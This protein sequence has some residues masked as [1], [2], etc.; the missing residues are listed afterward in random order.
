MLQKWTKNSSWLLILLLILPTRCNRAAIFSPRDGVPLPQH[1]YASF[2][3]L[4][5]QWHSTTQTVQCSN[6]R[7]GWCESHLSVCFPC[8]E[9]EGWTLMTK[10]SSVPKGIRLRESYGFSSRLKAARHKARRG[11]DRRRTGGGFLAGGFPSRHVAVQR[12]RGAGVIWREFFSRLSFSSVYLCARCPM[13]GTNTAATSSTTA[14]NASIYVCF[15]C[16]T[17]IATTAH[18]ISKSF[19]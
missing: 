16:G 2:L 6:G 15:G 11:G 14:A 3:G 9:K 1:G 18:V 12:L 4:D 13:P 5:G 17:H 7:E 10:E 19:Q 8:E